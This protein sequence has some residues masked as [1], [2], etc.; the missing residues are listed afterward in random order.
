MATNWDELEQQYGGNFKKFAPEGKY[1]TK[2]NKVEVDTTATGSIYVRFE[3]EETEQYKFPKSAQHWI[4]KKNIGWTKWH[5]KSLMIALGAS[6]DNAKLVIDKIT[7]DNIEDTKLILGYR[8]AYEALVAKK[9]EVEVEIR[10]QYNRNGEIAKSDKGIVY[11]EFEFTKQGVYQ[12]N[13]PKEK[14]DTTP[15]E[16]VMGET[17]ELDNDLEIPFL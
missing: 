8:K 2:I 6:E 9:P 12:D 13:R 17:E 15:V 4:S 3:A 5:H 1:K 16:E 10:P 7:P 11:T 14:K